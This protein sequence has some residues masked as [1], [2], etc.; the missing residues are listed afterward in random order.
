VTATLDRL[1]RPAVRRTVVVTHVPLLECQ[2]SHKPGGI[3]WGFSNAYFSNLTLGRGG[4][5]AEVTHCQRPRTSSVT[6]R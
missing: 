6:A 4:G 1:N 3:D 2:M 5:S